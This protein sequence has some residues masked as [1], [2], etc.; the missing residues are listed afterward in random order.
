MKPEVK[1]ERNGRVYRVRAVKRGSMLRDFSLSGGIEML[2]IIP[3]AFPYLWWL[4]RQSAYKVGVLLEPQP[5]TVFNV[6]RNVI[7]KELLAPGEDPRPRVH[8]LADDVRD[9]RF[10]R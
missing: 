9:G 5:E 2:V 3:L 6:R 10:D 8:E 1:I 4:S 7:Y